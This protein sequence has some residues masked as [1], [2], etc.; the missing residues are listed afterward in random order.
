MRRTGGIVTGPGLRL[1]SRIPGKA[2]AVASMRIVRKHARTGGVPA[3]FVVPL[4]SKP[5]HATI[6]FP[7]LLDYAGVPALSYAIYLLCLTYFQ[8]GLL[9][10]DA[11]LPYAEQIVGAY[12]LHDKALSASQRSEGVAW[13]WEDEYQEHRDIGGL[14][15]DLMGHFSASQVEEVL[16]HALTYRDPRLKCFALCSL[17]RLGKDVD[18]A[19]ARDVAQSA[20]MRSYLY[21]TLT[22]LC[23]LSLFPEE[24]VTQ[25]AFA[26][27]H[28]VEWL[29]FPTELGRVPDEIELMEVVEVG[30]GLGRSTQD[31]Y[32]FR[33]RT[34]EPHWA[35]KDGWSAG[36]T[37]PYLRSLA[38]SADLVRMT[39]SR[40]E[41]WESKTPEE[42]V[43]S[44]LWTLERVPRAPE[45]KWWT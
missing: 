19:H 13:M 27:S 2:A 8:R 3:S 1:L 34:H 21:R 42:H 37:G 44:V 14:L 22:E 10:P 29:T 24:Y 36:V 25:A 12:R 33:F 38:P 39:F 4:M 40:F 32:L 18:P 31:F 28:M 41:T 6:F 30:L 5:R 43:H 16:Q 20:E 26:E 15:L 9:A 45:P 11:L 17:L 35:A 7:D 23:A